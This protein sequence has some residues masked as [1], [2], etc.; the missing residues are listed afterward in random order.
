MSQ[1]SDAGWFTEIELGRWTAN[2]IRLV[3]EGKGEFKGIPR[4]GYG[5]W[6]GGKEVGVMRYKGGGD[7]GWLCRVDGFEWRVHPGMGAHRFGHKFTPVIL[8]RTA[9]EAR[10]ALKE[11]LAS[12]PRYLRPED[13]Q[14]A[15]AREETQGMAP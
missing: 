12:K 10:K 7:A 6:V 13:R 1:D 2:A 5:Y 14:E 3:P 8:V 4:R 11:V 9:D 15:D